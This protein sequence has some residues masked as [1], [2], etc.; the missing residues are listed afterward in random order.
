MCCAGSWMP[1]YRTK[2]KKCCNTLLLSYKDLQRIG[3]S[4]SIY[5]CDFL[6]WKS[7]KSDT[8]QNVTLLNIKQRLHYKGIFS[9]NLWL[10]LRS[11]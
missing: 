9:E 10:L 2:D 7:N 11:F 3:P 5:I 8:A 4:A 6:G 1:F